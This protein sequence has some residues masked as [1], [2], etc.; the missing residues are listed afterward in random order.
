MYVKVWLN[1]TIDK[2]KCRKTEPSRCCGGTIELDGLICWAPLE[3][4]EVV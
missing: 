1:R 3:I 2:L 4:N